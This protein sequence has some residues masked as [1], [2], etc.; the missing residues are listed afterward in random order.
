MKEH[1]R[2]GTAR[3]KIFYRVCMGACLFVLDVL[4][5]P[6]AF[7]FAVSFLLLLLLLLRKSWLSVIL[8]QDY[9]DNDGNEN[10]THYER[11]TCKINKE[12]IPNTFARIIPVC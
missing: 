1:Q 3:F 4:Y 8:D 7:T 2:D 10:M 5:L 12:R 11:V 6:L 9:R